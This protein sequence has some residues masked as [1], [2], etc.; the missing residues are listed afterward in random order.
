M[1]FSIKLQS[2]HGFVTA[3]HF[4]KFDLSWCLG[5][6]DNFYMWAVSFPAF[7]S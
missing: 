6:F 4:F 5:K 3:I 1:E 7:I 2:E